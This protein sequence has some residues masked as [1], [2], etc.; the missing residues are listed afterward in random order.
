MQ[1]AFRRSCVATS[2]LFHADLPLT[3]CT[4]SLAGMVSPW[5]R[6]GTILKHLA[7]NGNANVERRVCVSL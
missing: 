3:T 5:M 4:L 6:H 7:E 2:L 1:R